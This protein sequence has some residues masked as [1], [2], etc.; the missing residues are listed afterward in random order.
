MA[1][2]TFISY[3]YSEAQELRNSII[4]K[5]G[6]D[7]KYY[8]GETSDS[9]NLDDLTTAGIKE[10]LKD[11]IYSTSVLI[12]II[13]PKMKKSNWIDWEISYS[14]REQKRGNNNSKP[15]RIIAVI[16]KVNGSYEWFKNENRQ[17]CGCITNSYE[18]EKIYD[19]ISNNRYNRKQK[20]YTCTHCNTI[21]WW[22]GSYISYVEEDKFLNNVNKY[23]EDT[24]NKDC[25][26]YN[27]CKQ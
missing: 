15:N 13:S 12:I 4:S 23:I 19:I 7:A 6:E 2:K 11:M 9:P 22:T 17:T 20:E 27:L 16:K 26:D 1:R 14:L 10:K 8:T 18:E 21:N 5:L 3:K 24:Y 25:N